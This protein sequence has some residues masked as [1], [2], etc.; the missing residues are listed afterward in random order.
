MPL[1]QHPNTPHAGGASKR[2]R[3]W[4]SVDAVI[5]PAG[6][7]ILIGR[8]CDEPSFHAMPNVTFARVFRLASTLRETEID[9]VVRR[10]HHLRMIFVVI[11][12]SFTQ[13][14]WVL[15]LLSLIM[16]CFGI[17]F[18]HGVVGHLHGASPADASAVAMA[19]YFGSVPATFFTL[20]S[21]VS[22]GVDWDA[23]ARPLGRIS[24]AYV[25]LFL[26]YIAFIVVCVLNVVTGVF[27]DQALQMAQADR[28][29]KVQ[30]EVCQ[31][32]QHTH[33]LRVLF[34]DFDD[35]KSGA[36]SWSQFRRHMENERVKAYLATLELDVAQASGLFRLL[37]V[38]S[39]DAVSIDDFVA[40]CMRLKG[41]AKSID[42]CTLLYETRNIQRDWSSF[43]RLMQ[44]QLQRIEGVLNLAPLELSG[45]GQIIYRRRTVSG[46]TEDNLAVHSE[47]TLP[48]P[49]R[50]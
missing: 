2:H 33:G 8:A 37:D 26:A 12:G 4:N 22:G 17:V 44:C 39:S 9:F 46:N 14:L 20:F 15:L 7:A 38:N 45:N 27:V 25:V 5:V 34:H 36:L 42:V 24:S 16:G 21:A 19:E 29:L 18:V 48:A 30:S 1:E 31:K 41:T 40:G 35:R 10:V 6:F 49:S 13:L 11:R 23:V 47:G 28:D 50:R 32:E 43:S 3:A